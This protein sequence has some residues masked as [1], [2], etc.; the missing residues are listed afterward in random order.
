MTHPSDKKRD[1][2]TNI[3]LAIH[4]AL[5]TLRYRGL[6]EGHHW[7]LSD[8]HRAYVGEFFL[9]EDEAALLSTALE[10]EAGKR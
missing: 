5:R 10:L 6:G 3:S 8:I 2:R 9:S 7:S 4:G 1:P